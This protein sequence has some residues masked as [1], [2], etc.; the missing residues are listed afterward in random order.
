MGQ[1][2]RDEHSFKKETYYRPKEHRSNS[3]TN[4][5]DQLKSESQWHWLEF[6]LGILCTILVFAL[7]PVQMVQFIKLIIR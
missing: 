7:Y 6:I 5:S 2:D 4:H 3:Y 1:M